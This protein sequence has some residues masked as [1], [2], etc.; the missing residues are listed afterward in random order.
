M[1]MNERTLA[2]SLQRAEEALAEQHGGFTLFGL[3]EQEETPGRWDVVAS[4]PWLT[5]SRAGIG[6]LIKGLEPYLTAEQWTGLGRIVPLSPSEPFVQGVTQAISPVE[7]ELSELGGI[8]AADVD[9]RRAFVITSQR[10]AHQA[11][12]RQA[13]AA[14]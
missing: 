3:F 13:V 2:E 1:S 7:H 6:R 9:I 10:G 11:A 14:A 12:G 8:S 5:S 4:A